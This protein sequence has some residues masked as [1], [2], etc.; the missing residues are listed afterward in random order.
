MER[1]V[2]KRKWVGGG[3]RRNG[4]RKIINIALSKLRGSTYPLQMQTSE[5]HTHTEKNKPPPHAYRHKHRIP[6]THTQIQLV[7]SLFSLYFS[8]VTGRI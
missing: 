3:R 7:C 1:R 5:K 4:K 6:H 8:P 2:R